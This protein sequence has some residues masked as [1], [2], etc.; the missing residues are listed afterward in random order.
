MAGI[1]KVHNA[2][3]LKLVTS[4][5]QLWI[6]MYTIFHKLSGKFGGRIKGAKYRF[7]LQ[8]GTWDFAGDA[9]ADRVC[10]WER[11]REREGERE[12]E[13]GRGGV[14]GR[15]CQEV[16]FGDTKEL[17]EVR[18]VNCCLVHTVWETIQGSVLLRLRESKHPRKGK[19]ENRKCVQPRGSRLTP[20]PHL[21][22]SIY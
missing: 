22:L 16:W 11:E 6:K 2:C 12:R 9:I 7:T 3:Y 20:F 8:D 17:T 4:L 14:G 19:S 13:R 18:T 5:Y 1:W 15:S 10:V 21:P